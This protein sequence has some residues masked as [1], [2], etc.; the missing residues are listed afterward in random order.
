MTDEGRITNAYYMSTKLFEKGGEQN[1]ITMI[2]SSQ[3]SAGSNDNG[4]D[5]PL[6]DVFL[7]SYTR[8]MAG[9]AVLTE[10]SRNDSPPSIAGS[11]C[12]GSR[13]RQ[14]DDYNAKHEQQRNRSSCSLFQ[15]DDS[16]LAR[17]DWQHQINLA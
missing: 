4:T 7:D 1:L 10:P 14:V 6:D 13:Q 11:C 9:E 17:I 5:Y 15:R 8:V 2:Q 12:R 3:S 16:K